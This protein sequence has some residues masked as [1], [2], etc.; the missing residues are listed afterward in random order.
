MRGAFRLLAD[1][2]SK[3]KENANA[4]SCQKETPETVTFCFGL[5]WW[6]PWV[7]ASPSLSDT[8]LLRDT[9]SISE[10][11][12]LADGDWRQRSRGLR[13][14][15]FASWKAARAGGSV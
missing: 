6:R 7:D 10:T 15:S 4:N 1:Y 12:I 2:V 8:R 14:I 11:E 9:K 3:L 5:L 13:A